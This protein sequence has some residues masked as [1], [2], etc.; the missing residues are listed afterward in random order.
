MNYTAQINN[1]YTN[2][3][4]VT[5]LGDG[6]CCLYENITAT[7]TTQYNCRS[8]D[9]VTYYLN[10]KNYDPITLKWTN[11]EDISDTMTVFCKPLNTSLLNYTYPF[12]Q[13]YQPNFTRPVLYDD[14]NT[15]VR[16]DQFFIPRPVTSWVDQLVKFTF[17]LLFFF[18]PIPSMVWVNNAWW[19]TWDLF[20]YWGDPNYEGMRPSMY[21]NW[22]T[23][24]FQQ[25]PWG[26]F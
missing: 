3:E 8:R 22:F 10:P 16:S 21:D 24:L 23:R 19:Y 5:Q 26:L 25:T 1:C 9:F 6:A 17:A 11:P 15:N 12:N 2:S 14:V 18:T 13:T 4:C 7:N 20:S